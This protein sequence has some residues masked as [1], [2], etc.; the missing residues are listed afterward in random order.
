MAESPSAAAP[1]ALRASRAETRFLFV[2]NA[3]PKLG[4]TESTL[5]D[6]F[7]AFG[8]VD[9]VHVPDRAIAQCLVTMRTRDAARAAQAATHKRPCVGLGNRAPWVTFACD[10]NGPNPKGSRSGRRDE[11]GAFVPDD[12]AT[13]VAAARGK[14]EAEMCVAVTTSDA[15]NDQGVH[16]VTLIPEFVTEEEED[17]ILAFLDDRDPPADR[18]RTAQTAEGTTAATAA[19]DDDDDDGTTTTTTN[20]ERVERV[21][22]QRLAKR[23][24]AHFGFAFDYGTRDARDR[25]ENSPTG[26]LPG[27]CG[28]I[29]ER[30][31]RK[32]RD[33][34]KRAEEK[35][36]HARKETPFSGLKNATRCDQLTV[37]E[38]PAGVGLAPHV[39][40][41]SAFGPAIFSLSLAGNAV[42]EFRRLAD[43]GDGGEEEAGKAPAR[44]SVA[45]RR[46]VALPRRSML[47]LAGE[48]RYEWQ[49][50]IPHRKRDVVLATERERWD[51]EA[52]VSDAEEKETRQGVKTRKPVSV[53]RA[54]RRVSLTF[55]ERRDAAAHGPCA[56]AWPASCDSRRG[57]AQRLERRARPGLVA[58]AA[59][60]TENV[61]RVP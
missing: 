28:P 39:D 15:L 16:G 41:H 12:A 57:A 43:G 10:P 44:P 38:Y 59:G 11:R 51:S 13:R 24:V 46:A 17:A 42:M 53:K 9:D 55:R 61:F 18:P 7:G 8:D 4:D 6:V 36:A 40:T 52:R 33:A 48:A 58:K 32:A 37:N 45:E 5:R 30:L 1:P 14:Q 49:H 20:D 2:A 25:A 19:G 56:C 27:F 21:R 31:E 35:H 23:R 47:A 22:W 29:L 3:G 60:D 54:P 34:K 50:Y 26:A